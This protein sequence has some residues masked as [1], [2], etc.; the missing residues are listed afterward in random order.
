MAG[1]EGNC[2]ASEPKIAAPKGATIDY[3]RKGLNK[4]KA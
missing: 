3:S 4:W 1:P 2:M